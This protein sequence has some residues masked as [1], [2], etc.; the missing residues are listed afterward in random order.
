VS[1]TPELLRGTLRNLLLLIAK[2]RIFTSQELGELEGITLRHD[3]I[4][5]AS[6]IAQIRN[7][8]IK[9]LA[10]EVAAKQLFDEQI[11]A[12]CDLMDREGELTRIAKRKTEL[13]AVTPIA[14][15]RQEPVGHGGF[16]TGTLAVVEPLFR[17]VYDCGSWTKKPALQRQADA[18]VRRCGQV[19][20]RGVDVDLLFIS[21]FDADHVS[22]L[23]TLLGAP[24]DLRLRVHTAVSPYLSPETG[25]EILANAI[26]EEQCSDDL[27]DLVAQP[28]KYCAE[29]TI[30][31][32]L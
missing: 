13:S 17:W 1:D 32:S 5:A 7:R 14:V 16:H 24:T 27:I 6:G 11:S 23:A 9:L 22:G 30:K 25:F 18:F 31:R 21:H 12:I 28:T 26:V 3:Q 19:S 4:A 15:V 8:L 10:D 20:Q 29:R 2:K